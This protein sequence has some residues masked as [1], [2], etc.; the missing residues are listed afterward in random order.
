MSHKVNFSWINIL[1]SKENTG[2]YP[3]ILSHKGKRLVNLTTLK[4]KIFLN[5]RDKTN[6]K[7]EL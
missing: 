2:A 6:L 7:G 5:K 1:K 4:L 3:C